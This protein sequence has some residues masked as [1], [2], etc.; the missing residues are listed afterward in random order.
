[1]IFLGII[2]EYLGRIYDESKDRPLYIVST[3]YGFGNM[4]DTPSPPVNLQEPHTVID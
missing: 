2:G 1:L 3:A 4:G